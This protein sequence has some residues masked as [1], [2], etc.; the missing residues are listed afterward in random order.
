MNCTYYQLLG[1][2]SKPTN[3][4]FEAI[5]F[6]SAT[7]HWMPPVDNSNCIVNYVIH[8]ETDD[9]IYNSTITSTSQS[10]GSLNPGVEYLVK[11]AAID[12]MGHVSENATILLTLEGIHNNV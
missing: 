2:S 7:I 3:V 11:V 8:L 12:R 5:N 6:T 10:V 1:D 9:M 4:S